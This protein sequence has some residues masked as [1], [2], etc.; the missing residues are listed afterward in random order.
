MLE[1]RV[2]VFVVRRTVDR[3]S[4]QA[5]CFCLSIWGRVVGREEYMRLRKI[6]HE[7]SVSQ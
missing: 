2:Y 4:V 7:R 6:T 3:R 1:E 5:T